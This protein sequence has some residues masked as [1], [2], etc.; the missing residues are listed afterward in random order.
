MFYWTESISTSQGLS[1][2]LDYFRIVGILHM[3]VVD[4]NVHVVRPM[5]VHEVRPMNVHV[6]RHS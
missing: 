5:N 6:V 4:M 1:H 2:R 3:S